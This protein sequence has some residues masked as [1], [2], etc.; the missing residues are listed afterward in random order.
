MTKKICVIGA[1][2][3]GLSCMHQL[4]TH[5]IDYVCYEKRAQLGGL[6]NYS[7]NEISVYKNCK[8]NHPREY[9]HIN[10][11]HIDHITDDYLTHEEY[12]EYLKQFNSDKIKYNSTVSNAY[13]DKSEFL[14]K[15]TVNNKIESFSDLVICTGHYT[16]P[17]IPLDYQSFTGKL[18]HSINYKTPKEFKNQ[19]VLIIGGGSSAV[20]IASDL[21]ESAK[22]VVLSIRSM[23][24]IL[25][26]YI[27]NQTLFD[28]YQFC[29]FLSESEIVDLLY[30][31]K[32]HQTLFNIP[33]PNQKI[34][35]S[36]TIP[37][38]D[39]IFS[40][41]EKNQINFSGKVIEINGD[42]VK[43]DNYESRFDTIILATGYNLDF[44]FFDFK[45]EYSNNL[46]HVVNKDNPSLYFIGML[47][48]VGPVPRLLDIQSKLVS[49][50]INGDIILNHNDEKNNQINKRVNLDEYIKLLMPLFKNCKLT[51]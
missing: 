15:I 37:I 47:Q 5:N 36:T 46:Y 17:N 6:W 10:D 19:N 33:A 9:M 14:W 22:K 12:L 8:Q 21:V 27:N 3:S 29:Q 48:P 20:Q 42:I 18:T 43:F 34:L 45:I 50:L 49:K 32:A 31:Y 25:P 24:Y 44:D 16:K 39:D 13:Y 11:K 30:K 28:F 23:P 41:S 26:R 38:C 35:N 51:Y 40:H 2:I 7:E 1:G 4:D